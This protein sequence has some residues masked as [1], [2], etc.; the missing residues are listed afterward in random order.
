MT[1]E[2]ERIINENKQLRDAFKQAQ[3]FI[4]EMQAGL[5]EAKQL[6]VDCMDEI[7]SRD[8]RIDRLKQLLAEEIQERRRLSFIAG[9]AGSNHP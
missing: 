7:K 8:D 6:L 3:E 2:M 4:D 1:T 9:A 5:K